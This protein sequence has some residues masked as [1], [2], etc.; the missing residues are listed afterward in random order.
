MKKR[1]AIRN[2]LFASEHHREKID[3]IGDPL[4]MLDQHINIST[5][6]LA[7][8]WASVIGADLSRCTS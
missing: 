4:A 7:G 3:R 2:D 6:S 1:S 5:S 8:R